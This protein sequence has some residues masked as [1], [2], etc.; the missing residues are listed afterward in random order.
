MRCWYSVSL[1]LALG[2][3]SSGATAQQSGGIRV[4]GVGTAEVVPDGFTVRVKVSA[5]AEKAADAAKKF[6][7]ARRRLDKDVQEIG[8]A[9]DGAEA[10]VVGKGR[11]LNLGAPPSSGVRRRGDAPDPEIQVSEIVEIRFDGTKGAKLTD[12][13]LSVLQKVSNSGLALDGPVNN[14]NARQD[15]PPPVQFHAAQDDGSEQALA[16]AIKD[17]RSRAKTICKGMNLTLG[18]ITSISTT[19]KVTADRAA[20]RTYEVSV[21]VVFGVKP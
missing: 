16:A 14:Y 18:G 6:E 10:R 7:G 8:A 1:C 21:S 12:T 2:M 19:T 20:A 3:L 11:Q 5:S 13:L 9:V 15:A 4:Q 17:A